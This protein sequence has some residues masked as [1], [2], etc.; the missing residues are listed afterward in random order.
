MAS[1]II[2]DLPHSLGAA[3]AKRRIQNGIGQL[4][5]HLP[6]GAQVEKNW[7]GDRM[8]LKVT[9][10]GQDVSASLDVQEKLVR[11]EVTLPGMLSFFGKQI[12]GLLRR[13]GPEL[14][15]D[16]SGRKP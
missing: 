15:E 10:L 7:S 12:E 9:A 6:A 4:T 13:H 2:V 16:R 1:P 3:E 14:L 5:D 8:N 11:V